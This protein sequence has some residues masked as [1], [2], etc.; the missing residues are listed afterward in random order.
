MKFIAMI[1]MYVLTT[2][3]Y[4]APIAV[5]IAGLLDGHVAGL[6]PIALGVWLI[7]KA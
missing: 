5:G 4:W 2:A 7:W 6:L 1:V 3:V